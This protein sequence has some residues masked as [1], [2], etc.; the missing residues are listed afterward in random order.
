[1][2]RLTGNIRYRVHKGL[3]G[4]PRLVLQVEVAQFRSCAFGSVGLD[5]EY[6]SWRDARLEDLQA[7]VV[8]A[9]P[10]VSR[11][12]PRPRRAQTAE[13]GVA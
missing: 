11:Y 8:R 9:E 10:F 3:F 6:M 4:P 1:M 5:A 13:G 7:G 2:S 12:P